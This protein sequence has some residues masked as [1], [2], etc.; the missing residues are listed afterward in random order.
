MCDEG[1]HLEEGESGQTEEVL[2][3]VLP[4]EGGDDAQLH[5]EVVQDWSWMFGISLQKLKQV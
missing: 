4:S 1:G 2:K 5:R 3:E